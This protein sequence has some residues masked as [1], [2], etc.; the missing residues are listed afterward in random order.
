MN[1][2]RI[3]MLEQFVAEDPTD[4]FNRYALALELAKSDKQKAKEIFDQLIQVNPDYVAA[5]Y[6]A[7]L[8]YL[9]LSLSNEATTI[10][11]NGI[12][13]AKKQ[14]NLKAASE[15]RGLLDEIDN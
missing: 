8:L 4:P 12:V 5:Y 3:K 14:N 13:Q 10:I 6:Q 2:E 11:E 9:E 15:L 7:A 1:S